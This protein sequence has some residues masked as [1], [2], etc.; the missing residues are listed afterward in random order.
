YWPLAKGGLAHRYVLDE[1]FATW[2][3]YLDWFTSIPTANLIKENKLHALSPAEKYDLLV[4][5]KAGTL[6]QTMWR[7]GA[8]YWNEH[9]D[10]ETW[11]GYC[12]GWAAASFLLPRPTKTVYLKDSTGEH[13]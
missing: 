12:H 3:E 7:E 1:D 2:K 4:G 11:M 8:V 9:G 6:T 10:V 5:D 13:E